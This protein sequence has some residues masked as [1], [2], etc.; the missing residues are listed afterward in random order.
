MDAVITLGS[1]NFA[2]TSMSGTSSVR[3]ARE[4]T[5]DLP[6]LL[7][8][9]HSTNKSGVR[10]SM[11]RIDIR[12]KNPTTLLTKELSMYLVLSR[13]VAF[14]DEADIDTALGQIND[15]LATEALNDSFY[16]AEV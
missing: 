15:F 8:I 1:R 5:P 3:A 14:F 2:L 10:R 9:S 7:S 13:D 4:A 11:V 6:N 12:K 16:N